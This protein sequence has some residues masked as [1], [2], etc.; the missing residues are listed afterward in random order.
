[1]ILRTRPSSIS[2]ARPTRPTPAL[3]QATVRSLAP[4]SISPSISAFGWPTAPKPPSSTVEPSLMPA[5]ASAIDWTILLIMRLRPLGMPACL[6]GA[7]ARPTHAADSGKLTL[8]KPLPRSLLSQAT[9]EC[10]YL[11]VGR[12]AIS[13]QKTCPMTFTR[14]CHR[15]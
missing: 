4:C 8:A 15:L 9:Q 7:G 6:A 13:R 11:P 12:S 2:R 5:M 10:R 14:S 3:L 1:M